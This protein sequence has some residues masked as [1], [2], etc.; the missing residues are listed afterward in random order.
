MIYKV[1]STEQ[2]VYENIIAL[3]ITV[4][5]THKEMECLVDLCSF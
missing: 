5:N 1:T 4:I 3:L 2:N